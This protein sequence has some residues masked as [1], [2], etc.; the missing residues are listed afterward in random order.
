M[1]QNKAALLVSKEKFEFKE[2]DIPEPKDDEVQLRPATIGICGSDVHYWTHLQCGPFK[3]NF[4]KDG[5]L[6]LGHETSA[7]VTK[8]GKNVNH[9]KVGDRVCIEPGIP[10]RYCVMCKS[11]KY[12]LCSE[13]RFHATPPINGTFQNYITHPADFCFKLNKITLDEGALIEPLSVGVHACGRGQVKAGSCVL[14]TGPGPIGI[15]C[16]KV[17]KAQGA[18]KVIVVGNQESRLKFAKQAGADL[19]INIKKMP[20][21]EILKQI[22]QFGPVTHGFECSGSDQAI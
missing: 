19:I 5:P 6:I 14:I 20:E 15:V 1:S 10:C 22:A 12:N 18:T 2:V 8:V 16:L 21:A 3:I 13:M 11:G 4:E 7:V 9:L 17:A